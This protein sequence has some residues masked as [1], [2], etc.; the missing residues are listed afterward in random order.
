MTLLKKFFD[1]DRSD[2]DGWN[3]TQRE[4]LVD[5]LVL[6]MYVDSDLSLSEDAVLQAQIDSFQWEGAL[7]VEYYIN[8]TIDRVRAIRNTETSVD[9][10][11][12]YIAD[13]LNDYEA[14]MT[15]AGICERLLNADG[16]ADPEK[17][18]LQKVQT[19]LKT[20]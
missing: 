3:Q 16:K 14:R 15:A 13:R 11:L 19:A 10:M 9:T 7:P 5:L 4:A 8:N 18:F 6:S 2:S 20:R 1:S 12:A 17:V